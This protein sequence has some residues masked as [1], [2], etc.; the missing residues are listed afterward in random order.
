MK[1]NTKPP[2]YEVARGASSYG[3]EYLI[4]EGMFDFSRR[5]IPKQFK[6]RKSA[7]RE[8]R[9]YTGAWVEAGMRPYRS[10]EGY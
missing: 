7:E 3:I 6:G 5:S 4:E 2:H 8:A 10:W 9:K 1:A